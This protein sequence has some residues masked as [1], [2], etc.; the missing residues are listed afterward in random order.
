MVMRVSP[1]RAETPSLKQANN[2]H[3]RRFL[4]RDFGMDIRDFEFSSWLG[5][6]LRGGGKGDRVLVI[7]GF[8]GLVLFCV[9]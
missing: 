5:D 1:S 3:L 4:E 9:D 8:E 7:V 2:P 6:F